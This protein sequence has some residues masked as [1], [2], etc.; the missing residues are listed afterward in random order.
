MFKSVLIICL[1]LF[2][3]SCNEATEEKTIKSKYYLEMLETGEVLESNKINYSGSAS[4][5][6][7][8]VGEKGELTI[9]DLYSQLSSADISSFEGKTYP[10]MVKFNDAKFEGE[11]LIEKIEEETDENKSHGKNFKLKGTFTAD[12]GNK[13]RYAVSLFRMN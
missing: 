4:G 11:V 12:K 7:F 2:A 6:I 8:K 3:I 13:V 10:G 9:Y 1:A 5:M